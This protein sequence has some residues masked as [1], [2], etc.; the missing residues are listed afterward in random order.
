VVVD[1]GKT[2]EPLKVLLTDAQT[3][4][5]LLLCVNEAN[6]EKVLG[7]LANANTACAAVIGRIVRGQRRGPLICMIP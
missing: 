3:S 5:G 4:G 7:V 6:L 2:N 1:W